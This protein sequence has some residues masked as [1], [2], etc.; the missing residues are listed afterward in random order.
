MP[1]HQVKIL[2]A[3]ARDLSKLDRPV[4]SRIVKRLRWLADRMDQVDPEPLHGSLSGFFKLRVG[5]HR[6][7]YELPAGESTIV[8]HAVGHRSK[9]YRAR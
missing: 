6:V 5:D 3:A 8:V 4:A 9:I 2:D 1:S 7:V